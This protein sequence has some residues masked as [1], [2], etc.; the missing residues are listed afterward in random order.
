MKKAK[1]NCNSAQ[2]PHSSDVIRE[3]SLLD[4]LSPTVANF[5]TVIES[6]LEKNSSRKGGV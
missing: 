4:I 5:T 3:T 6:S 2:P 1:Q